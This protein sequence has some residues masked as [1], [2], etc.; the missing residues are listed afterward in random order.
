MTRPEAG[1]DSS[2][3]GSDA[4][5]VP[6]P[7]R[8]RRRVS[9][10]LRRMRSLHRS[11]LVPLVLLALGTGC[12]EDK[13]PTLTSASQPTMSMTGAPA[14]EGDGST[15]EDPTGAPNPTTNA[16]TTADPDDPTVDSSTGDATTDDPATTD[17][18]TAGPTTAGPTTADPTTADPT[19]A[20]PTADPTDDPDEAATQLCVD[21][22]NMY[23]ATLGL[24]AYAR[25]TD[26]EACSDGEA[27]SDGQT[28][29]PH[30]AFGMCGESAQ[31]ECPGWPGPPEQMIEGC[32]AQMWAEG[33]GDDF[34]THG[35]YI[36]MSS[37]SYSRVACGFAVVNGEVWA[38]QN[39]Q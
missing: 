8:T 34:P 18:T 38:V 1:P 15:D 22:I 36:N 28:N 14:T 17:P 29:T 39:F 25:W 5:G 35:H 4:P 2:A 24:P 16:Q 37:E 30:G 13:D 6:R 9:D 3:H 33:P 20:D 11:T 32:L 23:R 10:T 26:A 12:A 27:E 19:T 7:A 21:T 31:N